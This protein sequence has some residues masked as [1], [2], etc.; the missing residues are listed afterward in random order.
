MHKFPSNE[1][2]NLHQPETQSWKTEKM[3]KNA[4]M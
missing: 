3:L 4:L 2:I 1:Q